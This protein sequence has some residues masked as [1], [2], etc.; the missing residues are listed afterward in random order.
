MKN[1][2]L[3]IALLAFNMVFTQ[4]KLKFTVADNCSQQEIDDYEITILSLDFDKEIKNY[5]IKPD[6]TLIINKGLYSITVA[7][8]EREHFKSYDFVRDFKMD[9]IYTINLELPRIMKKYTSVIHYP[10]DLGFYYCDE[11]CNGFQQ[12]FYANGKLRMEGEF[13]NGIPIKKL[14]KYNES[15]VL[16]EIELYRRNGTFKKSKYPDYELYVKNK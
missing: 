6:S 1:L 14:N 11:V 3:I 12:D 16:V 13:K 15:G 4:T 8:S 9:T 7:K 2:I 10:E 5:F